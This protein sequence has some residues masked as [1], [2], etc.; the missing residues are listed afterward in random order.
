VCGVCVCVCGVCVCACGHVTVYHFTS[1][2][3]PLL[4]VGVEWTVISMA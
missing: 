1:L 4:T 3:E 2:V